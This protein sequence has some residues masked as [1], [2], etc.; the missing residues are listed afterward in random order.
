MR[1]TR[2]TNQFRNR[3][4]ALFLILGIYLLCELVKDFEFLYLRTDQTFLAENIVCKLFAI[5]VI[6][7]SLHKLHLSWS[8]IGFRSSGVLR[9]AALGLSL[10]VITFAAS[11]FIEFLVLRGMGLRPEFSFYI[12]NFAISGQNITGVSI[13]ALA[14]CIA[15]NLVNVWAEEGLFRGLLLRIGQTAFSQKRANLIQAALFGFWHIIV[16][17]VWLA[18]G[19]ITLPEALV[20]SAGY[21]LL[22]GIL[23]YEWGLC[24]AM[25][26]TLWAGAFEH[27]FN[28]FIGNSLHVLTETGADELQVL[29]I[30]ISNLLSLLIVIGLTRLKKGRFYRIGHTK[31]ASSTKQAPSV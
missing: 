2:H 6:A 15:G 16:A 26:G 17:A 23:G 12:A 14:V 7:F 29:R 27:F 25:T 5:G 1:E 18:D 21:L 11:Y 22:A 4:A 24:A 31:T 8:A 10:G 28:N 9:G 20:M 19:S 13:P 3:K 30:L